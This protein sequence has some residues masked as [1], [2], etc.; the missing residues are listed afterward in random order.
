MGNLNDQE[1][2]TNSLLY[3]ESLENSYVTDNMIEEMLERWKQLGK[4]LF[5]VPKDF[6]DRILLNIDTEIK[7]NYLKWLTQSVDIDIFEIMSML[8]IYSRCKLSKRMRFLFTLFCY[9]PQLM[10]DRNETSFMINKIACAIAT[11]M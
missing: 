9:N 8:I 4:P 7:L 6:R 5:M 1:K 2:K 3:I 10:M 11:T